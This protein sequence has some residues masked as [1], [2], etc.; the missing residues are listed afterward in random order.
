MSLK[1]RF[2]SDGF[3]LILSIIL[4]ALGALY[5]F[6]GQRAI[7][8]LLNGATKPYDVLSISCGNG[9]TVAVQAKEET[10]VRNEYGGASYMKSLAGTMVLTSPQNTETYALTD[11]APGVPLATALP[12]VPAD[13]LY[14]FPRHL[15]PADHDD[16]EMIYDSSL[17]NGTGEPAEGFKYVGVA[18]TDFTHEDF[19]AFTSCIAKQQVEKKDTLYNQTELLHGVFGLAYLADARYVDWNGGETFSCG[20]KLEVSLMPPHHVAV[21][22]PNYQMRVRIGLI[23]DDHAT[24]AMTP[25][26]INATGRSMLVFPLANYPE[27][28]KCIDTGICSAEL[29]GS[30]G[31]QL[32]VGITDKK[33]AVSYASLTDGQK[34]SIAFTKDYYRKQLEPVGLLGGI[35]AT[36]GACQNAQG[37]SIKQYIEASPRSAQ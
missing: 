20:G 9:Y 27:A 11:G 37:Q 30:G 25:D 4:A 32:L 36:F 1:E 23:G 18:E 13:D 12:L 5:G 35:P 33:P 22:D 15:P 19:A 31:A 14:V 7:P 2:T 24:R 21:L 16:F 26:E 10:H 8:E 34:R 17:G 3:L 29:V 6:F 28:A